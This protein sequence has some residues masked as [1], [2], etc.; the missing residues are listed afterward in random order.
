MSAGNGLG[1]VGVSAPTSGRPV[2]QA[3][4][5]SEFQKTREMK[6]RR[7]D[8]EHL[9]PPDGRAGGSARPTGPRQEVCVRSFVTLTYVSTFGLKRANMLRST[10]DDKTPSALLNDFS[11]GLHGF[12]IVDHEPV[13][14][15]QHNSWFGYGE[16]H[17]PF[18]S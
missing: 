16:I 3:L 8:V 13:P 10:H 17:P 12:R 18:T 14:P 5:L 15:A 9:P 4:R 2:G 6:N 7:R 1:F 11:D